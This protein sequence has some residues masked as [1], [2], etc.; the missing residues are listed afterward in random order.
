MDWINLST[1]GD[2]TRFGA[3][4]GGVVAPEGVRDD[5]R[6]GFSSIDRGRWRP[7]HAEPTTTRDA[8][9][10]T[11]ASA[12]HGLAESATLIASHPPGRRL[13]DARRTGETSAGDQGSISGR[14]TAERVKGEDRG[15]GDQSASGDLTERTRDQEGNTRRVQ[16]ID[17]IL[18]F[19]LGR[20]GFR[21][22]DGKGG[23][24]CADAS[25]EL[26]REWAEIA[27]EAIGPGRDG[28]ELLRPDRRNQ[29]RRQQRQRGCE[30][31]R[32]DKAF[33]VG[34]SPSLL[35]RGDSRLARRRPARRPAR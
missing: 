2:P 35:E 5:L 9:P 15:G 25:R 29:H 4:G 7:G 18:L 6:T 12:R 31:E 10:K 24:R 30:P 28:N 8:E 26:G 3:R 11:C 27:R 19:I 16:S 20:K 22:Q 13:D 32:G 14:S 21:W 17:R 1:E 33:P 34:H 23:H